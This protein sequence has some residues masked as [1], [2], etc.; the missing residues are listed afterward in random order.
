MNDV[1]FGTLFGELWVLGLGVFGA[2]RQRL[3]AQQVDRGRHEVR[4]ES[5]EV[6]PTMS[7][8]DAP[9]FS[10]EDDQPLSARVVCL[11]RA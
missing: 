5:E 11:G 1:G 6:K 7:A 10:A 3:R 4:E 2:R 8:S 9:P